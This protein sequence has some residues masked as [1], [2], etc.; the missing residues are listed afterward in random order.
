MLLSICGFG[1]LRLVSVARLPQTASP[2]FHHSTARCDFFT[3]PGTPT[4]FASREVASLDL[5]RRCTATLSV[6]PEWVSLGILRRL[7]LPVGLENVRTASL[8]CYQF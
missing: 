8:T 7:H 1:V 3:D 4:D 5:A 2:D 6:C